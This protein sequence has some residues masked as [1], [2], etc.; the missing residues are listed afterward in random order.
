MN[1]IKNLIKLLRQYPYNSLS[2]IFLVLD[3]LFLRLFPIRSFPKIS[4]THFVKQAYELD[5]EEEFRVRYYVSRVGAGEK[6]AAFPRDT[7]ESIEHFYQEHD[8]DIWRQAQY[9]KY[10]YSCKKKILQTYHILKKAVGKNEPILDFGCG[11]GVLFHYLRQKGFTAVDAADIPS[12]TLDFIS[13][14]M[15]KFARRIINIGTDQLP[16]DYAAI[17]AVDCLEHVTEPVKI[18]QNLLD[19]L[20]KDGMLIIKFPKEDDF[21]WTH[22]KQAQDLRAATFELIKKHCKTIVPELI[23]RKI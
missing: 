23:Y 14:W 19:S 9:S 20:R 10:D 21:S 4:I 2:G 15:D 8:M 5:S 12:T 1:K 13:K 7:R 3:Y 17:V 11:S 22:L 16:K 6:W 18:A